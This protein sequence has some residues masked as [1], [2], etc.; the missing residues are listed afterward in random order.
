MCIGVSPKRLPNYTDWM[1]HRVDSPKGK[2]IYSHRMSVVE[3]VFGNIGTN[4]RLNRFSLR[5]KKK[6]QGQWQLYCLVHNIEK[7]ANYGQLAA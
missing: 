4:K 7:L 2:E 3:P 6:V 1:K 5:G